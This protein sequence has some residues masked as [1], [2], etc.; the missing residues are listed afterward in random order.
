MT[1]KA[2]FKS[3]LSKYPFG[4]GKQLKGYFDRINFINVFEISDAIPFRRFEFYRVYI[5]IVK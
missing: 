1:I 2:G 3:A 5:F 4:G